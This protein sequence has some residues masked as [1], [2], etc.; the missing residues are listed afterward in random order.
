M[1]ALATLIHSEVISSSAEV[2]IH[3]E[4]VFA[5]LDE[6]KECDVGTWVLDTRVTLRVSGSV[7]KDRHSGARYCVFQ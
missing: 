7:H 3:E 2:E 5:H 6:E 4:K 1:L